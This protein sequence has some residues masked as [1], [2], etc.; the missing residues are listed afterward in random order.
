VSSLKEVDILIH[1]CTIVT[2]DNKQS[3]IEKGFIT[4]KNGQIINVS[5]K[6]GA[7]LSIKAEETIDG[8]GKVA[9]PG[10]VNCHTH[11]AM[12][13]FRGKAEDLKLDQWLRDTIWP[14]EAK[15][16]P[17]DIYEGALLGCLEMIKSG[18]TCFADMYFHEDVIAK[19]VEKAG[20]RAVLAPG[21]IEAG[22]MK[23]GKR[24][25][26]DAVD[27]AKEYHGSA[28][29]RVKAQ[30]GPHAFYSCSPRLLRRVREAASKLGVSVH[31]HLAE[32]AE[33]ARA[34]RA[35][36]GF[37]EV[38]LLERMGFLKGLNVLAA[39]C[40]HL[41]GEEMRLL[42]K[43]GVRVAYNPVVNMKLGMGVPKIIELLRLG[44]T[45]GIGTDGPASNNTL[46]MFESMKAAALLQKVWYKDPT[47]LPAETVLRMATIDGA[48][49]LGLE[50]C[51]G[52]VEVGKRADLILVD[53][54]KPHLVPRHNLYAS[55]VY[56][57]RGSD[58]DTVVVD[59]KI[60]MKGRQVKTL[61]EAEV[62][63][64]AQRTALNLVA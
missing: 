6:S 18:T 32:S 26:R 41:S 4:I 20:L 62:M 5:K 63:R 54:D 43:R 14:L 21:I 17:S 11:A 3:V 50:E 1:D 60:L 47:V 29:G 10:L 8:E 23:R 58:V 48:K 9:L 38:E 57:A 35:K 59:G 24:M 13:L 64:K 51:V 19:A 55:L 46:D 40:V 39:H 36:Y 49:A 44:V 12:T 45:V 53:F 31:I 52:S 37:G 2:M 56:S 30:L 61:N 16:K 42:A 22:D 27:F 33:T 7:S 28:G 15:L 25:L 34:L